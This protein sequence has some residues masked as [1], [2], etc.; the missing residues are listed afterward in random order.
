MKATLLTRL[1]QP[2]QLFLHF[3]TFHLLANIN[4]FPAFLLYFPPSQPSFCYSLIYFIPF[5][6]LPSHPIQPPSHPIQPS[7]HPIQ[8]S[9]YP[10][11]PPS[12]PIQLLCPFHSLSFTLPFTLPFTIPFT[13]PFTLPFTIPFTLPFT[14]ALLLGN[15]EKC[16]PPTPPPN[17]LT[18]TCVTPARLVLIKFS[19]K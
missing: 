3:Y 14:L 19:F 11:Q 9:S 1:S 2:F 7:F 4:L 6:Q 8:P 10:I 17:T 18:P 5:Y 13:L 12:H 16:F 15:V